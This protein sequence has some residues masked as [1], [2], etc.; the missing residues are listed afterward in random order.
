MDL[1]PDACLVDVKKWIIEKKLAIYDDVLKNNS[2]TPEDLAKY[3]DAVVEF[4][5]RLINAITKEDPVILKT[6]DWPDELV[7]CIKNPSTNIVVKDFIDIACIRFPST[8][9]EYNLNKIK[10]QLNSG[11]E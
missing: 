8:N 9:S 3:D 2:G 10:E 1:E 7:E 6:L 11:L 4:G 5:Y